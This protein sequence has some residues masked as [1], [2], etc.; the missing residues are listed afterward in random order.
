VR[1]K[2]TAENFWMRVA[3]QPSGCWE[4]QGALNS[5][6]YGSVSW[7]SKHYVAHRLAAFLHGMVSTLEAPQDAS[8]SGFV[9]HKCDNRKCCNPDHL[10]VG[11]Y[12]DNQRD[13]YKK[14]RRAQPK[15]AA[16]AN[17]KLTTEQ[18]AAIRKSYSQGGIRQKDLGNKYG[19]SQRAI[20]LV[21]RG[22]TYI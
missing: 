4:W 9:L 20:S 19:V 1:A 11:S 17:S 8:C 3:K 22:E 12:S 6:G 5:T 16:H 2:N 21:V 18:V 7:D 13:A 10:F 14:K 15:G